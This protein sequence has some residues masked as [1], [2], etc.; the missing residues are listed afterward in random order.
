MEHYCGGSVLNE[1][2]V[3]TAAH[4]AEIV[5]IGTYFSDVVVV[6]QHDRYQH[7]IL[8]IMVNGLCVNIFNKISKSARLGVDMFWAMFKKTRQQN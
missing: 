3:L 7:S 2:W 6:G 5:F 1:N 8:K 4:C